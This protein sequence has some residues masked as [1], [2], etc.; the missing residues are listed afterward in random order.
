MSPFVPIRQHMKLAA[1][2]LVLSPVWGAEPDDRGEVSQRLSVRAME[3]AIAKQRASVARMRRSLARQG[4]P[5]PRVDNPLA[6]VTPAQPESASLGCQALSETQVN[7]LVETAGV[8]EGLAVDLLKA[9]MEKESAFQPCAVSKKGAL[10]LMQLMPATITQLSV[11]DP[12]DPEESVGAGAKL[13]KQLLL[14]Y[15]GDLTLA[16]SAYN[17][18]PTAVDAAGGVPE[19]QET[20]DYVNQILTRISVSSDKT[21]F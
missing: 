18:G 3:T 19:I 2:I 11:R 21:P 6:L 17:A 5:T 20:M 8:R 14:R 13:L 16:L 12:F 9:V 1:L 7:A 10:G 4:T 15:G